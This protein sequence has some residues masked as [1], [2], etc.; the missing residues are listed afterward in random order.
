MT[1]L[2]IV[3]AMNAAGAASRRAGAP[4]ISVDSPRGTLLALLTW[5]DPNGAY[6]DE[7]GAIEGFDPMTADDAWSLLEEVA[8]EEVA[9]ES[10]RASGNGGGK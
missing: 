9:L 5:N 7:A 4:T 1:K 6:T 3:A 2:E 10:C 8:L